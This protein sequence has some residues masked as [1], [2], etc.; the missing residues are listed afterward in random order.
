MS[1]V[2]KCKFRTDQ[3]M[4]EFAD[5]A[6]QHKA[7]LHVLMLE[8]LLGYASSDLLHH[9]KIEWNLSNIRLERKPHSKSIA[10]SLVYEGILNFEHRYAIPLVIQRKW[11][12]ATCQLSKSL[13]AYG[14]NAPLL[15]LNNEG[16]EALN[17]G[18]FRIDTGLHR[19]Q[20][21]LT[22]RE[23]C[24]GKIQKLETTRGLEKEEI[25]ELQFYRNRLEELKTF[26]FAVWDG[27][28]YSLPFNLLVR[29]KLEKLIGLQRSLTPDT[30]HGREQ[31]TPTLGATIIH[32]CSSRRKKKELFAFAVACNPRCS[33]SCAAYT[34]T[35]TKI[36][37]IT[38]PLLTSSLRRRKPTRPPRIGITFTTTL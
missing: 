36:N 35:S 2:A 5:T 33:L 16:T 1:P 34:P 20:A 25:A 37:S 26:L 31:Y 3:P 11:I 4:P 14:E 38:R 13:P 6:E 30:R 7:I 10:H 23:I 27:G 29:R 12:A 17:A 19:K 32:P 24:K 22:A 21:T 28:T 9:E 15:I 18:K 8:A